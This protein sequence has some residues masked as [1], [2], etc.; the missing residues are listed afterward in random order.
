M[1]NW[2]IGDRLSNLAFWDCP[3]L[4]FYF[5]NSS[6]SSSRGFIGSKLCKR[7]VNKPM[8]SQWHLSNVL[9]RRDII[10]RKLREQLAY[11]A[12]CFHSFLHQG[13]K[14]WSATMQEKPEILTETW[15]TWA[16]WC[17][18]CRT[19]NLQTLLPEPRVGPKFPPL[20]S[21]LSKERRV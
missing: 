16:W 8:T 2:H 9:K 5:E 15:N 14:T 21:G 20:P 6:Y 1:F 4:G 17:V 19:F 12:S 13:G 10:Q 7:P 11:Q 18:A 3:S